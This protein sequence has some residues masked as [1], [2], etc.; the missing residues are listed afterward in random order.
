MFGDLLTLNVGFAFWTEEEVD[1]AY[2]VYDPRRPD[3]FLAGQERDLP[4]SGHLCDEL[5][6]KVCVLIVQT[7][8]AE[9]GGQGF[10]AGG[11]FLDDGGG[12]GITLGWEEYGKV[13]LNPSQF[14][15]PW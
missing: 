5:F 10:E 3:L 6:T 14:S 9:A 8:G 1:G 7:L 4:F 13:Y 12:R 2:G 15:M 11:L